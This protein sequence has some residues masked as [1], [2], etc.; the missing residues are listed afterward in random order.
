MDRLIAAAL[1]GQAE[2]YAV[3]KN[4]LTE[5]ERREE[6]Q[7]FWAMLGQLSE[8]VLRTKEKSSNFRKFHKFGA[9]TL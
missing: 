2:G 9:A 4:V 8:E 1:R 5:E 3:L 6:G 7:L